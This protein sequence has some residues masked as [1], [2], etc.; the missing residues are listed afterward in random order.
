MA[1]MIRVLLL[2][3]ILMVLVASSHGSVV[4]RGATPISVPTATADGCDQ[5]A[6]YLEARQKIFDRL[7]GD[8][9]AVFPTVATPIMD[10]GEDLF[11]ALM[12]MTPEQA[13]ALSTAYANAADAIGKVEAPPIAAFYNQQVVELY[14]LSAAVFD[15]TSQSDLS[16]AGNKYNDP[17]TAVS[18]AIAT[19]AASAVAVCPAFADV[20]S[21][22]Q[23]QA[24]L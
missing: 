15:E 12:A 7:V 9:G 11:A 3:P 5:L 19:Y 1:R 8:I 22:D 20:V 16:T 17:L 21:L 4:A 13:K 10:H 18:E 24:A 2:A 14:R 6:P 23:T